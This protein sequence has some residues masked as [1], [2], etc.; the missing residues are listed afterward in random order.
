MLLQS[1]IIQNSVSYA[2]ACILLLLLVAVAGHCWLLGWLLL[3]AVAGCSFVWLVVVICCGWLLLLHF[4][5]KTKQYGFYVYLQFLL[6]C[7]AA[8]SLCRTA[9][10]HSDLPDS[11][12]LHK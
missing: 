12:G 8:M 7:R 2:N 3:F 9:N 4:C 10:S 11:L 6:L 1:F 5:D